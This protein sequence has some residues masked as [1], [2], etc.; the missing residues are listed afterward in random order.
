MPEADAILSTTIINVIRRWETRESTFSELHFDGGLRGYVLERPG[1]D[2]TTPNLN[3]RVPVGTYKL[4]WHNSGLPS[5]KANNPVPLL[6]NAKVGE[7]RCILIHNGNYPRDTRGCL[8]VGTTMSSDMVGSSLV[9]L[10]VL[11]AWLTAVGIEN[12]ELV[13][14]EDYPKPAAEIPPSVPVEERPLIMSNTLQGGAT[15]VV[16]GAGA[17][18]GAASILAS[19]SETT[20]QVADINTAINTLPLVVTLILSVVGMIAGGVVCWRIYKRK[21]EGKS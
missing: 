16:T 20:R 12:V 17:A 21:K 7:S 4:R 2:T 18:T 3:L 19:V 8:L 9:M 5:V 11:K 1:P 14:S 13:I 6:Y 10:T 15:A